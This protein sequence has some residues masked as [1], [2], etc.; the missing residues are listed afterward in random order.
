MAEGDADNSSGKIL[1][2]VEQTL[3][4]SLAL[5]ASLGRT[6]FVFLWSPKRLLADRAKP[7]TNK[8]GEYAP[9]MTFLVLSIATLVGLL[10]LFGI[11]DRRFFSEVA[12]NGW[13]KHLINTPFSPL[14]ALIDW[15]IADVTVSRLIVL[16]LPAFLAVAAF[17]LAMSIA[18]RIAGRRLQYGEALTYGSYWFGAGAFVYA[19]ALPYAMRAAW[20]VPLK[21]QMLAM[22][23]CGLLLVALWTLSLK[24]YFHC[25]RTIAAAT[26]LRVLAMFFVAVNIFAVA[27]YGFA[28]WIY[29]LVRGIAR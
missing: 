1:S 19:I 2:A 16:A 20:L 22:G 15:L 24:S 6:M 10:A 9:P 14:D 18:A 8:Y 26:R 7:I 4:G 13:P 5:V 17:A 3:A 29:P 12:A 25:I 21:Y 11:S 28:Y 27:I 23:A